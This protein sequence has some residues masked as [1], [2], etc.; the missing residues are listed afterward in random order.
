[1]FPGALETSLWWTRDWEKDLSQLSSLPDRISSPPNQPPQISNPSVL[2]KLY[3][4]HSEP[5]G[6]QH[7]QLSELAWA[8]YKVRILARL[9]TAVLLISLWFQSVP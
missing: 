6:R 8:C 1:M 4:C 7:L 2:N 3:F 9:C 5:C